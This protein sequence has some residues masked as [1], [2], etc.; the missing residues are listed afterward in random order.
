MFFKMCYRIFHVRYEICICVID[1]STLR[2]N[3]TSDVVDSK[4]GVRTQLEHTT[5]VE[6]SAAPCVNATSQLSGASQF[7]YLFI[8]AA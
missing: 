2:I 5:R 1:L 4:L 3:V 8:F 7:I 6:T